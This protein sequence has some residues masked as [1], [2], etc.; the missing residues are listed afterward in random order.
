MKDIPHST[1]LPA[2]PTLSLK[3][4]QEIIAVYANGRLGKSE[5][6]E[7]EERLSKKLG[8]KVIVFDSLISK[9]ETLKV[10]G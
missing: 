4:E 1:R 2:P 5:I 3:I 7:L 8:K 9:V 6:D 10:G